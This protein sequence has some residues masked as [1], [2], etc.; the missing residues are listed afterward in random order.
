MRIQAWAIIVLGVSILYGAGPSGAQTQPS[1]PQPSQAQSPIVSIVKDAYQAAKAQ[2]A[3]LVAPYRGGALDGKIP[4]MDEPITDGMK[5]N[6]SIPSEQ[7]AVI[8]RGFMAADAKC[9]TI[10]LAFAREFMPWDVPT[11]EYARDA[12]K[13]IYAALA[14]RQT[15]WGKANRDFASLVT[16][17]RELRGLLFP[18]TSALTIAQQDARQKCQ[19]IYAAVPDRSLGGKLVSGGQSTPAMLANRDRPTE[20]EAETVR[21][22]RAAHDACAKLDLEVT[23]TY[24]PWYLSVRQKELELDDDVFTALADRRISFG[25]AN[26]RFQDIANRINQD[27]RKRVEELAGSKTTTAP[28]AQTASAA[29]PNNAAQ[30]AGAAPAQK[31]ANAAVAAYQEVGRR[32]QDLFAPF[33]TGPLSGKL[34]I[35]HDKASAAMLSDTSIPSEADA[36]LLSDYASAFSLCE[37]NESRFTAQ[38]MPWF[39]PVHERQVTKAHAVFDALIAR[40]SSFGEANRKLV[41]ID[42]DSIADAKAV[43][44]ARKGEGAGNM[45]QMLQPNPAQ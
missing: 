13:P 34:R 6:E 2:C 45:F 25:E 21:A 44:D 28:A 38:Y 15:S 9:A 17:T 10:T 40:K 24:I 41:A 16:H 18:K 39:A 5:A 8:L 4:L 35:A 19:V 31:P 26:Q 43:A 29:P 1:Q 11:E 36:A 32:C 23:R 14:D 30:P 33:R 37:A 42:E 12:E 20:A 7:E 3:T 22:V 27:A